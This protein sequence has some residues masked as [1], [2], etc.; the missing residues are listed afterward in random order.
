MKKQMLNLLLSVSLFFMVSILLKMA[1]AGT[2]VVEYWLNLK[3]QG[4]TGNTR[5]LELVSYLILLPPLAYGLSRLIYKNIFKRL[6][7]AFNGIY[8]VLGFLIINLVTILLITFST[9]SIIS[10]PLYDN[11]V[12]KLLLNY[13]N[14]F[15]KY[16]FRILVIIGTTFHNLLIVLF[17]TFGLNRELKSQTRRTLYQSK[18]NET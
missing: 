3:V 14:I 7:V 10:I 18:S 6:D 8:F 17:G 2:Q 4:P 9:K 15:K 12:L 1:N 13:Q 11:N 16:D 5:S